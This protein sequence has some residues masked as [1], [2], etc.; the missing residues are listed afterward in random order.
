MKK[1]SSFLFSMFF[2]GILVVIFAIAIG[3]ATFIENDYGTTTAKILIY[4]SRWFEILL[5]ILCINLIGSIFKYK[6]VARKKWTVLLFHK[7]FIIVAVG[8]M[9]TRYF[10]YE[11][12]M[13][14]RENNSSDFIVSEASFV[15]VKVT[16]GNETVEESTEVKFSPYTAN[17]FS[18]KIHF[19]GKTI[20]IS[21]KQFMPSAVENI[22]LDPNGE[23]IVSLIT[24]VNGSSRKDFILRNDNTKNLNGLT[25]GF[26]NNIDTDIQLSLTDGK[27]YISANDSIEVAGMMS[28]N[29][30]KIAP[31]TKTLVDTQ[32]AY[33][34]KNLTFA[35]KQFLP[36]AAVQ[37]AYQ[38]PTQG[39]RPADAFKAEI[40]TT[41][42]SKELIVYGSTGEVG[43]FHTTSIEGMN[44]SVSYGS[45]IIKLPFSIHLNDFQL[46][47]YPG[48]MSPSSYASEVVLKDGAT[49]MPFRIFMNNI[50]KYKG[51]RFFQS[52][53]DTDER[54]TILSVNH[55]SMGTSVTYF[56][57]LLMAIG[58]VLTLFNK[59]SRFKSLLKVSAQLRDKRKKLF[60]VLVTG[61]LLSISAQAQNTSL[62]PPDSD[63][64][65]SFESLL[66]QDRKGRVE[67]VSTLSSEILRKIAKKTS[68]E[69]LTPSE[70]F[71]EMQANPE[72]WKN[73]AIIKVG[74]PELRRMI[75]IT[76]KYASFN[77]IV[78][79]REMG[80][81]ILSSAVQAAYNKESNTRNKFD[82]EIMNV[83]ERVN[84]LMSIFT[85]DFLT[86]FPVPNDDN[87][88][89]VSINEAKELP[90][91]SADFA[92]QTVSSY[93]QSVQIRHWATAN[94][95]LNNL[96]QNQE[97]IGAKI[98]P[99]ATKVKM[100]VLYNN[101]N[102]FGKLSKIFMFTGLILLMLQLVSLFNPNI[103][104]SFLKSFAFYFILLLFLAETAGLAIR[105]YISN[106]A[107]W[108]N[109]YES[110][111]FI[112]W[113]T[114][115]GGLIFAKRSEITLSLTSVLAGLTL[116][117]AGMS[118]M[119]PEITNLVPVLKSYWLIVH[120]AV[121]TASYGFLGISALLG[122]LNL[123]LMVF[124]SKRNTDRINHTIKEL[125]NIIQIALIIGLLM[126]TLGSFLGGVWANESWGRYWGW[127]PKET[128]ALVT[129]LVYTFITHMHRIPG[130]RG[131]FAMSVAAVLGISSVLMTY[132]G[133]NYYLSGLHSYAQGEAAPIPS[134]VYIA[135]IVV[136]IVIVAAYFSERTSPIIEEEVNED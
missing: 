112:S 118:W 125:V 31:N 37:L 76:G 26:G 126:V 91:Q 108:S 55:D 29:S 84:I 5:F 90:A 6:L 92:R 101:L 8:A 13:H 98:I 63:H 96:K 3:Y 111:V 131:S 81:Y 23:P 25:L 78:K 9:I 60:T 117:V 46:E 127:D 133:V 70:V 36:N 7:A 109:G 33:T 56:G 88:K 20:H 74:N 11:G 52:S 107:P 42:A 73:I 110:M 35:V 62:T 95:L 116:M 57:Y 67:P 59:S 69:G 80:G 72:K 39:S 97:T 30:E 82:K 100:E 124:R 14:I 94:Q 105:W 103:K 51:Y 87:H 121:I 130:M 135:V 12:S 4:N 40:S 2:T 136:A 75:G 22:I 83:D 123:I 18:K 44:V 47:R 50:L 86:I 93:L 49:E 45:R 120:V 10:G 54:G 132:F 64:S 38:K 113:A 71:L 15:T 115:L 66:I 53:Y 21:N 99:S 41:G 79:P 114:A 34:Y 119:S 89:W 19:N 48:S 77:S 17:R 106:H 122:F 1:L 27:L 43:D 129:I 61:V 24:V 58:M 68:W 32:K 65:K 16:D 102:I 134:G 128:W 28:E 85:G 104:L